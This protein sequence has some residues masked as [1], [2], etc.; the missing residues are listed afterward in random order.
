MSLHDETAKQADRQGQAPL[1]RNIR[2]GTSRSA[3]S[4][5]SG[6]HI[7]P[8]EEGKPPVETGGAELRRPQIAKCRE[9]RVA[10]QQ[11]KRIPHAEIDRRGRAVPALDSG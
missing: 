5:N 1:E 8:V 2:S 11:C 4:V 3:R 10:R 7:A 6:I 9:S